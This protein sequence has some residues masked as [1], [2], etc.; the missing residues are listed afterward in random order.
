[1]FSLAICLHIGIINMKKILDEINHF[2]VSYG[3]DH[4]NHRILRT[5]YFFAWNSRISASFD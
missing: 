1:M 4:E 5:N 2:L 3:D